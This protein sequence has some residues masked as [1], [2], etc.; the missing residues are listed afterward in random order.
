MSDEAAARTLSA[1]RD[2]YRRR[3]WV[4]ARDGFIE[5]G[6][7]A[8]ELLRADDL[9]A[10]AD[11]SWWLGDLGV[12][13]PELQTA[14]HGYLDEDQPA[15][16]GITA[17]D[18]GYTLSLRG[19]DAQ[20]SAWMARATRLLDAHPESAERGYLDHLAF[21]AALEAGDLDEAMAAALRVKDRGLRLED[22]T[23]G[24]LG[25]MGE[26]RVLLRRGEVAA[27]MVCFD[28]AMLAAT[29]DEVDPGWAGNIY[30][31]LMIACYEIADL[32]RAGEWTDA[33]S[34][35]CDSMP[36]AG[37]FQ[38]ICR[39]HRAQ[40]LQVRG[41]FEAAEREAARICELRSSFDV[42][43]VAE[44]H[45]LLGE[46]RRQR[47]DL[48]GAQEAYREAHRYGR[49][50]QPGLALSR[51]AQGEVAAASASIA[52]ALASVGEQSVP[53]SR[54]LP[55]AV[56]VALAAGDVERAAALAEE[57]ER[58]AATFGT[59]GLRAPACLATGSV[60]L[61]HDADDEAVVALREAVRASQQLGA[62]YDAARA[63]LRL[64]EAY[65]RLGDREAA[66]MEWRAADETFAELGVAVPRPPGR[67]RAPAPAGLTAR[68]VEVLGV[69]ATGRS[70]QQIA[71]QLYLSVRTVERHL[72]TIYQKL[73]L[74]GRSARA[75][76]VSFA[77]REGLVRDVTQPLG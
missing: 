13:L 14:Y 17:I 73:G 41:A 46:L 48:A 44:A 16:A 40:L 71:D 37:P 5:V 74:T 59:L 36:G 15:R 7:A 10:R 61:A 72:A 50:P 55:A 43:I 35:W 47:G 32:R 9:Y 70:N 45:Y 67:R 31:H 38:G 60:A 58:V 39:V 49:D 8:P 33:T 64:A 54:L 66:A 26:G 34:R 3:D 51:L 57:L 63:R 24:A 22:G 6:A 11:C 69:V 20:A 53:R 76:A 68:E 1:A 18:I 65:T 2:A 62:P 19:D 29:S 42:S 52:T 23:L 4:A 12:A 56:E 21:E 75:G 77:L 30:C 25:S 27:G 28:E